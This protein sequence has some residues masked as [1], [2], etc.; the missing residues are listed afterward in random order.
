MAV[1]RDIETLLDLI[2]CPVC[3]GSLTAASGR[4][5]CIACGRV[6]TFEGNVPVLIQSNGV[7]AQPSFWSRLQYAVLGNPRLYDFHQTHGGG[8]PIAAQVKKALGDL[9]GAT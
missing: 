5:S 8:R 6:F 9:G 1:N 2:A 3:H 7:G 4:L